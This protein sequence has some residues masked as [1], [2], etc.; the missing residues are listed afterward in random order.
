[1]HSRAKDRRLTEEQAEIDRQIASRQRANPAAMRQ[2]TMA[3]LATLSAS[4]SL[5]IR[6]GDQA[7]VEKINQ[8][9]ID[10]GGDPETGDLVEGGGGAKPT[11]ELAYDERIQKINEHNRQ[12]TKDAMAAAHLAALKRKK[13]EEAIFR[14]RQC[15]S[16]MFTGDGR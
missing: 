16:R 4:R 6:R 2:Q 14:A 11:G 10:L 5:A 7:A 9:I 12:K 3:Q 8:Q 1:M 13:A 15:V